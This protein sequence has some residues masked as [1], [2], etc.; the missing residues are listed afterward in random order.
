MNEKLLRQLIRESLLIEADDTAEKSPLEA[1]DVSI[2]PDKAGELYVVN[3]PRTNRALT[4]VANVEGDAKVAGLTIDLTG[5]EDVEFTTDKMEGVVINAKRENAIF[6]T[7]VEDIIQRPTRE[8]VGNL[9]ERLSTTFPDMAANTNLSGESDYPFADLYWNDTYWSVKGT[10]KDTGTKGIASSMVKLGTL[11]TMLQQKKNPSAG[12]ITSIGIVSGRVSGPGEISLVKYGPSSISYTPTAQPK[13][14]AGQDITD[15]EPWKVTI[16]IGDA[17]TLSFVNGAY[18]E[19]GTVPKKKRK[20]KWVLDKEVKRPSW[21]TD[22]GVFS[23]ANTE[24]S[25]PFK[26]G[27]KPLLT[28]RYDKAS[29]KKVISATDY[30]V[31]QSGG[32]GTDKEGNIVH[33]RRTNSAGDDV[34]TLGREDWQRIRRRQDIDYFKRDI[35]ATM[36]DGQEFTEDDYNVLVNKLRKSLFERLLRRVISS[37]LL[38]E[39]LNKSDKKEIERI[40]KKQASKIVAAELDKTLG[41]SFFETKGKVNKF[42]SDEVSKR[43]KAGRRDPDFADTVET[44]CKEIHKKDA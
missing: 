20:T 42:V 18:D 30:G 28:I 27:A 44:I 41:S 7:T 17:G 34:K 6:A 11:V 4:I 19:N 3:L 24:I 22:N 9:F 16:Q 38:T 33:G 43:F 39:E 5:I 31:Y 23:S 1:E 40:A 25:I 15:V 13:D 32:T 36:E 21:V 29:A 10:Q 14:T 12:P 26:G 35:E 8:D 37:T 2:L